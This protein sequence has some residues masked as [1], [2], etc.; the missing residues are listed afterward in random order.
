MPAATNTA[1]N[2]ERILYFLRFTLVWQ[3]LLS[4]PAA[5]MQRGG[6]HDRTAAFRSDP[7]VHPSPTDGNI[8]AP[9]GLMRTFRGNWSI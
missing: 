9:S 3:M 4:A 5:C 1:I 8:A 6:L 2:V 7:T